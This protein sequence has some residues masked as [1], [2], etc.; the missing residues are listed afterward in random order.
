MER[1]IYPL[2]KI[3]YWYCCDIDDVCS[4]YK[5]YKLHPKTV[6]DWQKQGLQA[7]DGKKPALFYGFDLIKF[8][9]KLNE[10]NKCKTKFEE[11]FCVKCKEGKPPLKKQIQINLLDQKFLKVKAICQ[12]C[13]NEIH[14]SYKLS[15][16]QTLK[17]IFD[18]V[19]VLQLSDSKNPS[20]KTP[21]IDQEISS[22]KECEKDPFQGDLFQ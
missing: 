4:L 19:Q 6:L 10:A 14:K 2:N 20:V 15:D 1:R 9:G 22:G 18:V 21:F 5:K 11:I 12:T 13:K 17:R 8:L 16:L 3:K 7:I